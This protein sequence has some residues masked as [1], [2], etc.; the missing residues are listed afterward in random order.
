MTNCDAQF[1]TRSGPFSTV[2]TV[3]TLKA[4]V[5]RVKCGCGTHR[6]YIVLG[7]IK[8]LHNLGVRFEVLMKTRLEE[9]ISHSRRGCDD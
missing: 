2:D 9:G 5:I 3:I 7:S 8:N 1:I 4:R 6:L